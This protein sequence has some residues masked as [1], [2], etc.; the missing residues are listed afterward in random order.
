MCS[1]DLDS[2]LWSEFSL[3]SSWLID[4]LILRWA[5]FTAQIG[6]D[7]GLELNHIIAILLSSPMADRDVALSKRLFA[8][9][10]DLLCVWTEKPIKKL[11]IDHMI[12]F[13]MWRNND[14]W[15][16]LPS[17]E[18]INSSK[19]DKL[20]ARSLIHQRRDLLIYYWELY[21][22]ANQ[23]RFEQEINQFVGKQVNSKNWQSELFNTVVHA[24]EFTALQTGCQR[25]MP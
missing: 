22:S 24:I 6:R 13:T 19:S 10:P 16:L 12:P 4:A 7:D 2:G 25:W 3:L 11:A 20:P 9:L 14:L 8:S 5:Q 18:K 21:E 23:K 1:S 15:N 17:N